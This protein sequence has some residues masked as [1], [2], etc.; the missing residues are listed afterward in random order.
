VKT[1]IDT[2]AWIELFNRG[3]GPLAANVARLVANDEAVVTGLV[4]CEVL[5]GFR[6]DTAFAKARDTLAAFEEIEDASARVRERAVEIFRG[7]RKK[8]V[9]VRSLV[10]CMIAAAAIEVDLPVLHRDRDFSAIAKKF[11]L[12]L[13]E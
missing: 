5:A 8:G 4:R 13:T 7:C 1:I 11:P 6:S 12:R 10:D 9:T 2:S 3:E